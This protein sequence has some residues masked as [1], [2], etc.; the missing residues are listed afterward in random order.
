M[1]RRGTF[2]RSSAGIVRR[3]VSLVLLAWLL[4]FLWFAL[5]LPRPAGNQRTDAIVALTGANGRI[6]HGLD[7]L[8]AGLAPRMLVSGVD[9]EVA[10]AHFAAHY[11]VAPALLACCL[12][13]GYEAFDTR[14][15]AREAAAFIARYHVKSVRLVTTDWHMRRAAFDLRM[16]A[17]DHLVII[18][19]AVPSQPSMKVLFVE[20]NKLIARMLAWLVGWPETPRHR[21]GGHGAT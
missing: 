19:D 15:N 13:L 21:E 3:L 20:Y 10:P 1:A 9:S 8:R 17:P 4:G 14:S 5:W 2:G 11:G 18:E 16:A 12:T 6:A 7:V